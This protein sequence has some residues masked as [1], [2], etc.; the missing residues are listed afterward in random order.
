MGKLVLRRAEQLAMWVIQKVVE[1]A[2][3]MVV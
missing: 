2:V 3:T 1:T